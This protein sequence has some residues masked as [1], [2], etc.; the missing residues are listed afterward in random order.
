M[1]T[2]T[3]LIVDDQSTM[4]KILESHMRKLHFQVRFAEDGGTAVI[5]ANSVRPDI[6]LLDLNL[7]DVSGI[8]VLEKLRASSRT[9]AIPV[10]IVSGEGSQENIVAALKLGARDFIV[11]PFSPEILLRKITAIMEG[12]SPAA[13][14]AAATPATEPALA[15]VF[16]IVK[17]RRGVAEDEERLKSELARLA[18]LPSAVL[19]VDL[20]EAESLPTVF[21]GHLARMQKDIQRQG[22]IV[23]IVSPSKEHLKTLDESGLGK[24][25]PVFSDW[26]DV[27]RDVRRET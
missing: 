20:A 27:E 7:P 12:K 25:F 3:A 11:K 5:L 17:V 14:E 6:I 21:F 15:N 24:N 18:A 22:G 13:V 2:R 1:N 9:N 8:E 16:S 19:F 23:K 26:H 10:L 4:R